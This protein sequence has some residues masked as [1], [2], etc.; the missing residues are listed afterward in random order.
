M[1]VAWLIRG[2]LREYTAHS[3]EVSSIKLGKG[4]QVLLSI[5]APLSLIVALG[6]TM[7]S[8]FQEGYGDYPAWLVGTF[9][10]GSV[11]CCLIGA[12]VLNYLPRSPAAPDAK[13]DPN[14]GEQ[15]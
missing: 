12:I 4:W 9:G 6:L 13:P 3:N 10:W 15:S 8:L 2:K 14:T 5:I 1:L 11:L 7:N